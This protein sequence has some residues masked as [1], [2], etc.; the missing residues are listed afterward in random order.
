M[1][2]PGFSNFSNLKEH[3]KTHTA[4]KVFTCDEC[5]KS[6]NMQRKLV[7]HR[8]RHTGER[9]YSCSACG[10]FPTGCSVGAGRWS[11][12]PPCHWLFWCR[13]YI[14]P[15]FTGKMEALRFL[16]HLMWWCVQSC[17]HVCSWEVSRAVLRCS[18][19][20]A[21]GTARSWSVGCRQV[22][23]CGSVVC[24]LK[25]QAWGL[26]VDCPA[27]ASRAHDGVK[28]GG[29]LGILCYETK[30]PPAGIWCSSEVTGGEG[31]LAALAVSVH[32]CAREH[33]AQR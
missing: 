4:D 33:W 19:D 25:S 21:P 7:K 3:K 10:K 1:V 11:L 8:I 9:P 31:K 12:R 24:R 15:V 23:K 32:H 5:G 26:Q 2:S 17:V 20:R 27:G 18:A 30:E 13:G 14:V 22:G 29:L 16:S 6:F 28:E